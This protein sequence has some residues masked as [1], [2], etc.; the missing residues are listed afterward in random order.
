MDVTPYLNRT[1]LTFFIDTNIIGDRD[2]PVVTLVRL[3]TEGWINLQRTDTV[4]TE[5]AKAR[6][7]IRA[8]LTE[9]SAQY[10]ESYGPLVLDHSRT[11]TSVLGDEEDTRRLQK[12][13]S[14]MRPG[15][16]WEKVRENHIRDAMH[17]S[18][19]IRYGGDGF[20]TKDTGIL[21]SEHLIAAEFGFRIYHPQQAL[22]EAFSRVSNMRELHR[23]EP[24]RGQLPP[25]P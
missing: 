17:V 16:S 9:E 18:T 7:E 23:R 22:E 21:R 25:W 10:P 11:D 13:F 2:E 14:I 24:D 19:A 15:A 3:R 6:R 20:V 1:H 8:K 4:D 12:I 5:L